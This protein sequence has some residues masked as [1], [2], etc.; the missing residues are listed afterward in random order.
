MTAAALLYQ[1]AVTDTAAIITACGTNAAST[2]IVI[3]A[4][5]GLEVDIYLQGSP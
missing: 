3:P 5:S 1:G 4:A 2:L